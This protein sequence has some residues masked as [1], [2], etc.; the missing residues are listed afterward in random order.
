M[1]GAIVGASL[2]IGSFAAAS[3]LLE[4]NHGGGLLTPVIIDLSHVSGTLPIQNGGT[5]ATSY[6]TNVLIGYNGSSFVATGTPQLTVGNLVATSTTATSTFANTVAI[7]TTTPTTTLFMVT[8]PNASSTTNVA[9]TTLTLG[10]I[11]ATT[12]PAQFTIMTSN[13][14][15][16]CMYIQGTSSPTIVVQPNACN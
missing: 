11:F 16:S 8:N 6:P 4:P 15:T 9:S 13:G 10:N 1:F 2:F 5:N 3:S 12:S 14:S 7:G